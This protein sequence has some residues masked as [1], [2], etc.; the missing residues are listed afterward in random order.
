MTIWHPRV[1]KQ[2]ASLASYLYNHNLY[3]LYH[4]LNLA[5]TYSYVINTDTPYNKLMIRN[6]SHT[7]VHSTANMHL[8]YSVESRELL[9]FKFSKPEPVRNSYTRSSV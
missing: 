7:R 3:T 8:E 1:C 4:N 9:N 6:R 2:F 5:I